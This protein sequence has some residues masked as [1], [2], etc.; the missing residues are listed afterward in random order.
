MAVVL[1]ALGTGTAVTQAGEPDIQLSLGHMVDHPARAHYVLW[2]GP[3]FLDIGVPEGGF[4]RFAVAN[5]TAEWS[6]LNAGDR[7]LPIRWLP[8]DGPGKR[9]APQIGKGMSDA[10][11]AAA[12]QKLSETRYQGLMNA[13]GNLRSK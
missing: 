7:P 8:Y 12:L 13:A 6:Q 11:R 10:D 2:N 9:P 5:V 1:M 4:V 3:A